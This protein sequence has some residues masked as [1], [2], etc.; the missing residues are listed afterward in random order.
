MPLWILCDNEHARLPDAW[1]LGAAANEVTSCIA[2]GAACALQPMPIEWEILSGKEIPG[3][4]ILCLSEGA[5]SAGV[6]KARH[7]QSRRL[8][9][10]KV[11]R[12]GPDAAE[13][14][15]NVRREAGVLR[16]LDHSSVVGMLE[17]GMRSGRA[18]YSMEWLSGGHLGARL[19]GG[20]LPPRQAV[21]MAARISAAIHHI[22]CRRFI[23]GDLRPSNIVFS[24]R[25]VPKL[26][27]FELAVRLDR[28][29][30][31]RATGGDPRYM[32]P[33]Q[34]LREHERIGTAADIYGLGSILF[35]AIT[36]RLPYEGLCGI[37]RC[38]KRAFFPYRRSSRSGRHCRT[39]W[40]RSAASACTPSRTKD[41]RRQANSPATCGA[42]FGTIRR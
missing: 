21:R 20:P 29:G 22:H 5:R 31:A 14:R 24:G 26:V 1:E 4:D 23:Y 9:A 10:L 12:L 41:T 2:C 33:E 36:G 11:S 6:Y 37:D 16:K 30:R 7:M 38:D 18:F 15:S 27:D 34:W 40:I 35:H 25:G 13:E 17:S 42:C 39:C 32:A 28:R 8:V 19:C 3:Y